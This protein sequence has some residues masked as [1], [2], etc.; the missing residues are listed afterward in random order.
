MVA[1]A[2]SVSGMLQLEAE[3]ELLNKAPELL[4]PEPAKVIP[5]QEAKVWLLRSNAPPELI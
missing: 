5:C 1:A 4:T 3:E 2:E